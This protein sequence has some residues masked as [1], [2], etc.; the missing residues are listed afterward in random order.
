VSQELF[1]HMSE[2]GLTLLES[3]MH[4]IELIC[5]PSLARENAEL[6]AE[7]EHQRELVQRYNGMAHEL[8][9]SIDKIKSAFPDITPSGGH[10]LVDEL[11]GLLRVTR[12]QRDDEIKL[13]AELRAKVEELE[14]KKQIFTGSSK[15]FGATYPEGEVTIQ[16]GKAD[17][18]ECFSVYL[19]HNKSGN[20][21]KLLFTVNGAFAFA[22]LVQKFN[23][24]AALKG[25]P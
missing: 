21:R 22:K 13:N 5:A 7:C 9:A 19:K 3:E 14:G 1:N 11:I 23:N 24:P 12:G 20:S 17:G 6:R 25:Q 18:V 4:E 10:D 15:A 2:Y 8:R 16:L